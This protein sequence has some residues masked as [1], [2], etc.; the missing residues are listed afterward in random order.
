MAQSLERRTP[1]AATLA[2]CEVPV[3]T[4]REL[5]LVVIE[6]SNAQRPGAD[7]RRSLNDLGREPYPLPV[8]RVRLDRSGYG[9]VPGF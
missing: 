7:D 3:A 1:A 4:L 5:A 8:P 6:L 9:G 2:L